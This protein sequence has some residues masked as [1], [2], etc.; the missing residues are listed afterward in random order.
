M[1][2]KGGQYAD[3]WDTATLKQFTAQIL[4]MAFSDMPLWFLKVSI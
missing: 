2:S 4:L 1:W 3:G